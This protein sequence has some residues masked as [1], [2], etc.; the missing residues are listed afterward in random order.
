MLVELARDARKAAYAQ[1]SG[2][3]VGAACKA[4]SGIAYF[5]CNVENSSYPVGICAERAAVAGAIAHGEKGIVA[6]AIAGG[7]KDSR[8]DGEISP[9]GMCLQFLSEFM[10]PSGRILIADGDEGWVETTLGELLPHAFNLKTD[11]V[12]KEQM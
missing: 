3:T 9:C 10:A 12:K 11:R 6:L 5:G 8:P 1:Y 7:V 2:F 4:E